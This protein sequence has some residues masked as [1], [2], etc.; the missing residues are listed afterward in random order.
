MKMHSETV[1]QI[2]YARKEKQLAV[3][4]AL[5]KC[6]KKFPWHFHYSGYFSLRFQ[7]NS[8]LSVLYLGGTLF[9]RIT[10]VMQNKESTSYSLPKLADIG[11]NT[12]LL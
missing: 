12:F 8:K 3:L 9:S 5:V 11:R 4:L 7:S 6:I 10:R 1:K 2:C